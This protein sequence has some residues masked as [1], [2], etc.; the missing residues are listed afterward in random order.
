MI[1][2][3][4]TSDKAF[5]PL[6]TWSCRSGCLPGPKGRRRVSMELVL[7]QTGCPFAFLTSK[8]GLFLLSTLTKLIIDVWVPINAF[9][10]EI[11]PKSLSVNMSN[12]K[13]SVCGCLTRFRYSFL[14]SNSQRDC[15]VWK[16]LK[17]LN[18][19]WLFGANIGLPPAEQFP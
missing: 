13:S 4:W 6:V 9:L 18:N 17:K 11:N 5:F 19:L 14:Q 10:K 2:L 3:D 7:L 1:N 12:S 15:V 8:H 16:L